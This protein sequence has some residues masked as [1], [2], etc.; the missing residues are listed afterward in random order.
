MKRKDLLNVI[1]LPARRRYN[2][3]VRRIMR[4]LY[5]RR[6]Y[7]DLLFIRLFSDK[8]KLLSLYNTLN[9]SNYTDPGLIEVTTIDDILYLGVKN[10]CS[11]IISSILN[12]YEHQSTL[13]PNM[14]I[15]GL[16]YFA[17]IYRAYIQSNDL[18]IYGS[19]LVKLPSPCYVIFYNGEESVP[20]RFELRLSDA[21]EKGTNPCLECTATVININLGHS[22]DILNGCQTLSEYAQ[23]VSKVREYTSEGR[24]LGTAIDMA[25][26][27][28]IDN[29]ILRDFLIRNRSEVVRMFDTGQSISA[30]NKLVRRIIRKKDAEIASKDAEIASKDAEIAHLKNVEIADKNAEIA[31][32]KKLLEQKK[33]EQK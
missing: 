31:H 29:D 27:Y 18:D 24:T 17:S 8:V 14:P 19:T 33:Q 30:H 9:H 15:R 4:I 26:E 16:D 6:N 28:C 7:K 3:A 12:L 2:Y 32:L 10:D 21:F 23:L 11:F 20:D 5:P 25:V 13:N 22:K 1:N